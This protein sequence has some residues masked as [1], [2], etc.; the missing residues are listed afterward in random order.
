MSDRVAGSAVAGAGLLTPLGFGR[1]D[2]D[3][4]GTQDALIPIPPESGIDEIVARIRSVGTSAVELLVP[5][6]TRALQ[7]VAGCEILKQAA[8]SLG[9]TVT[10][11]SGDDRTISAAHSADLDLVQ[12]GGAIAAPRTLAPQSAPRHTSTIPAGWTPSSGSPLPTP[13]QGIASG[14]ERTQPGIAKPDPQPP[15]RAAQP[16]PRFSTAPTAPPQQTFVKTAPTIDTTTP[17]VPAEDETLGQAPAAPARKRRQQP[18]NAPT[19]SA[20]N[21]RRRGKGTSPKLAGPGYGVRMDA[22]QTSGDPPAVQSAARTTSQRRVAFMPVWVLVL[23][24]LG[25]ASVLALAGWYLL[26]PLGAAR[27]PIVLAPAHPSVEPQ[28][29]S[30][31][32]IPIQP[33]GGDQGAGAIHGEMISVPA[34]VAV[35]GEAISTTTTPIGFASGVL[36]LRNTLS[37]ALLLRGGT[38]LIAPNGVQFTVDVDTTIPASVATADGITFGRGQASVTA[39]VP[40]AAGNLP[41]GTIGS[42]PGFEGTLRVEQQD[43]SGGTDQTVSIVRVE[44][45]NRILPEALSQLYAAGV[46][47]LEHATAG[48]QALILAADTIT[49]TLADLQQAKGFEYAVFPPVGEVTSDGTFRL[50]VRGNFYGTATPAAQPIDQQVQAAARNVL[51]S[52]GR[53]AQDA[54][55]QITGWSLGSN[56]IVADVTVQS[57][58]KM[59]ALQESFMTDVAKAIAGKPRAVAASYLDSLVQDGKIGSYSPLPED[60]TVVPSRV[61]VQQQSQ[62]AGP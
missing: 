47:G 51:M 49:P 37:Q 15:V 35:S 61:V 29:Y 41:G 20:G 39:T 17:V 21:S 6:N 55:V 22:P 8:N 42:I 24:G 16:S 34:S 13:P 32:V 62:P 4:T 10:L 31:V 12:V 30:G 56:G 60:W 3:D 46:A 45:I 25:V 33:E 40:G 43:F 28:T 14:W 11:F 18:T 54:T 53:A 2:Q 1:L 7:S 57:S 23:C 19:S 27:T 59:A 44:D 38:P 9:V 58:G 48:K 26:G 5:N 52:S 36:V 50:E